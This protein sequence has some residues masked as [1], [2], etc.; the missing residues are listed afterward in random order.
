[1]PDAIL[2]TDHDWLVAGLDDDDLSPEATG[3]RVRLM[4]RLVADQSFG[5]AERVLRQILAAPV[6]DEAARW[7]RLW[8]EFTYLRAL[9]KPD[10]EQ[11][12]RRD[13]VGEE[14]VRS[15]ARDPDEDVRAE[16]L[17]IDA[18]LR[19][20][21]GQT[22]HRWLDA[23]RRRA[24]FD[25]LMQSSRFRHRIA[26]LERMVAE[27][28]AGGPAG[29]ANEDRARMLDLLRW[30]AEPGA[31]LPAR[32][33]TADLPPPGAVEI[34][35]RDDTDAEEAL[36]TATHLATLGRYGD[37]LE[38]IRSVAR[39]AEAHGRDLA[40]ALAMM[41][42]GELLVL[43][44]RVPEAA[45]RLWTGSGE[46]FR[47][48][49]LDASL[50]GFLELAR[51]GA[52]HPELDELL[53][54]RVEITRRAEVGA[55][56]LT[57][58]HAAKSVAELVHDDLGKWMADLVK[59]QTLF[60]LDRA[61]LARTAIL[62]LPDPPKG[63]SCGIGQTQAALTRARIVFATD[64]AEAGRRALGQA[65]QTAA[66]HRPWFEWQIH[67]MCA[68]IEHHQ[69]HLEDG[70]TASR[71]ALEI[72]RSVRVTVG[73]ERD[74]SAWSGSRQA[75]WLGAL[76][77][78]SDRRRP[79]DA[80]AVIEEAK[81][82]QLARIIR[83]QA[84]ASTDPETAALL[85]D[86]VSR[87]AANAVPRGL[88]RVSLDA[89]HE[90]SREV[91][92]HVRRNDAYLAAAL[93][94]PGLDDEALPGLRE[95]FGEFVLID[96][97]DLG[98]GSVW[99]VVAHSC[100]VVEV[101]ELMLEDRHRVS[102]AS[103]DAVR[104]AAG[105]EEW[106]REGADQRAVRD[107]GHALLDGIEP[108]AGGPESLLISPS[109]RLGN[110]PWAMFDLAGGSVI[111]HFAV[112]LLPSLVLGVALAGRASGDGAPIMLCCDPVGDLDGISQQRERLR[113]L[114]PGLKVL[115]GDEADLST[116]AHMSESGELRGASNLIW[117]GHGEVHPDEP[118]ASGLQL[119]DGSVLTAG[120][121]SALRLPA[122]VELWTC[123]SA[124][125]RR[126]RFDEQLGIV[127]ACVRAGA[128]SV[129]ASLWPLDD[130][131]VG[132]LS[133]RYHECL[134]RGAP[135][136]EAWR[137]VQLATRDEVS[138]SVW[139]AIALWGAS[140]AAPTQEPSESPPDAAKQTPDSADAPRH[141]HVAVTAPPIWAPPVPQFR[142]L[143]GDVA[144]VAFGA[145]EVAA[146]V[147]WDYIGTGHL[148][149]S[150]LHDE[151][152]GPMLSDLGVF[153]ARV[154][155][156]L[157]LLPRIED[158]ADIRSASQ[159]GRSALLQT[160]LDDL[161][162]HPAADARFAL[163]SVLARAQSEARRIVEHCGVD[164]S[165]LVAW[166][167]TGASPDAQRWKSYAPSP[168]A[169]IEV[170]AE[171][172]YEELCANV[173]AG[174]WALEPWP[175][176]WLVLLE[177]RMQDI[178]Q[179]N[180]GR[181]AASRVKTLASRDEQRAT[182]PAGLVVRRL[183]QLACVHAG[184]DRYESNA[185]SGTGPQSVLAVSAAR[186]ALALA[187]AHGF[188]RLQAECHVL[189]GDL[190]RDKSNSSAAITHARLASELARF[191]GDHTMQGYAE[192]TLGHARDDVIPERSDIGEPPPQHA[193]HSEALALAGEKA[194]TEPAGQTVGAQQVARRGRQNREPTSSREVGAGASNDWLEAFD[195]SGL[196]T[197]HEAVQLARTRG[198]GALSIGHLR[199]AALRIA[200]QRSDDRSKEQQRRAAS[201]AI[202]A[203]PPFR[204]DAKR[205]L[206]AALQRSFRTG[207]GVCADDI[208]A[209][210]GGTEPSER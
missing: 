123:R 203:S 18:T 174:L 33:G 14:I 164:P 5:A 119:A 184:K 202:A 142:R 131:L 187:Q 70:W 23:T 98:G 50:Q 136:S 90:E 201:Q 175:R 52:G 172:R 96:Y 176:R 32:L 165:D 189:L 6:E 196:A 30:W 60:A 191:V 114:W 99:R 146:R 74:G 39:F 19:V 89:A 118:L 121:L 135:P 128:S 46:L 58:V 64:G 143:D 112:T 194:A 26:T 154:E 171:E 185:G 15:F 150:L 126:L 42:E 192:I 88:D 141:P 156:L 85:R 31:T 40:H 77:I 34:G 78:A 100:E 43:V 55:R 162:R 67:A 37:A 182:S 68:E 125:E 207:T 27:D 179:K 16:V 79:D 82:T 21:D 158:L 3:R 193:P 167:E 92:R 139:A 7:N 157:L 20:R 147:G 75:A 107:L 69:D 148:L 195:A 44:D 210:T 93:E 173:P 127:A 28:A 13:E 129:L 73:D 116:L 168:T 117:A 61:A 133:G 206:L 144:S 9:Q 102:L 48:G 138:A 71:K 208:V 10:H 4:S 149:W 47:L 137:Q 36:V 153:P 62:D 110:V 111:D 24:D 53:E 83:A 25:D 159:S 177:A 151:R 169:L 152:V 170:G 122:R 155:A 105:V 54:D 166:I 51:L 59:A 97:L 106:M 56:L 57:V 183:V 76:R 180:H 109:G 104:S 108:D 80:L 181:S 101:R 124:A 49:R 178:R 8:A 66:A 209:V 145:G 45:E 29:S 87:L 200:P 197:L 161:H 163:R 35:V 63:P 72:I 186:T 17:L 140:P 205:V 134:R 198:A 86:A 103:L 65:A 115:E 199:E 81:S 188:V 2:P 91:L 12:T 95:L 160:V 38:C 1:M 94:P 11:T 41:I 22:A 132:E 130:D 84:A 120:V 204:A 190:L 113:G